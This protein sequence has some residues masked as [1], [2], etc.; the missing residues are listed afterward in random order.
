MDKQTKRRYD[1]ERYKKNHPNARQHFDCKHNDTLKREH[2]IA[3]G[4]IKVS[5][6]CKRCGKLFLIN[7][8]YRYCSN[9]CRIKYNHRQY[10]KTTKTNYRLGRWVRKKHPEIFEEYNALRVIS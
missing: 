6:Y 3:K 10:A 2:M 5:E 4:L 1:M 7:K 8:R 9:E